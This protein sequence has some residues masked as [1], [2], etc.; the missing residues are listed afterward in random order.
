MFPYASNNMESIFRK[1]SYI[2]K[3]K[4][5]SHNAVLWMYILRRFKGYLQAV[6]WISINN[7]FYVLTSIL[8]LP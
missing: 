2:N 1:I 6:L 3:T 8:E 4:I 7:T 5:I